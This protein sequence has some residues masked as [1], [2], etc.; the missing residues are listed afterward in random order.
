[1]KKQIIV[2]HGG[3]TFETYKD[4]FSYLKVKRLDFE[5]I[6][7]PLSGWKESLG[8][9]FGKKFE[10]IYPQMPNKQNAKY[11]EWK[12][13]FETHIPYLQ[14]KSIFIGHSLGGIFLAKYFA[15]NE[16]PKPIRAVFL[17]AAPFDDKN[18]DYSLADFKLP[19]SLNKFERQG[20]KI[21]I[22]QSVDDPVVPFADFKKYQKTLKSAKFRTFKNREHFNQKEL[23]EIIQDIKSLYS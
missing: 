7:N 20:G 9:R 14:P 3:D 2:I 21:F 15:E 22:Y 6:K 16:F 8:K 12:I 13:W 23:P 10:I 5:R 19:K 4:W 11:V 1:M 18:S 17:I